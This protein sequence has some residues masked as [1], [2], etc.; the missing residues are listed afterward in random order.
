[1]SKSWASTAGPRSVKAARIVGLLTRRAV[2]PLA[3]ALLRPGT[4]RPDVLLPLLALSVWTAAEALA[5][6]DAANL[7][8][9]RSSQ[10]QDRGTRYAMLGAHLL[11]W[12]LPLLTARHRRSQPARTAAGV[13]LI[14]AGGALRVTAVLTL[15]SRFTG[16][17]RTVPQ[18][19]VCERGPYAVVRHPSYLGLI[20]LNV[21]P[22]LSCGAWPAVA[23]AA[24]ATLAANACR[25]QVEESALLEKLGKP[26]QD[27][28]TRTPRY[29]P[30]VHATGHP[31]RTDQSGLA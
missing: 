29:V 7:D 16:H 6:D 25:V 9:A 1:M 20:G 10:Q 24:A 22:A 11:A 21:G 30:R 5:E 23:V 15:G 2:P 27:Y 14:L 19:R 12:W 3:A 8:A 28:K 18:Q 13:G 31:R 26:Y 17:V 4:R